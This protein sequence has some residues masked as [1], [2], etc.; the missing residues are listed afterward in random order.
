[1]NRVNMNKR[2]GI[3]LLELIFKKKVRMIDG[4]E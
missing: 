1:M 2:T 4:Q 3:R